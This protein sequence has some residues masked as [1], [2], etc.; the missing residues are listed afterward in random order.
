M[1]LNINKL[2]LYLGLAI[3][4]FSLKNGAKVSTLMASPN[5]LQVAST[6]GICTLHFV[7]IPFVRESLTARNSNVAEFLI[8]LTISCL[9]WPLVASGILTYRSIFYKNLT[10]LGLALCVFWV[11]W[12]GYHPTQ[13]TESLESNTVLV[14][15]FSILFQAVYKALLDRVPDSEKSSCT[16]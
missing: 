1:W 10:S 16:T 4:L 11:G 8:F 6:K 5:F 7:K 2:F 14:N 12:E 9:Q 13:N 15:I 3:W